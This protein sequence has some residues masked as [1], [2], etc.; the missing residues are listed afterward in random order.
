MIGEKASTAYPKSRDRKIR[1]LSPTSVMSPLGN[2]CRSGSKHES[3]TAFQYLSASKGR[4]KQMFS[5]IVAFYIESNQPFTD[6]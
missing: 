6:K 3:L 1:T 5:L 2:I 4:P